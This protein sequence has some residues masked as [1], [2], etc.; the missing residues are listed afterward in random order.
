M[1][2]LSHYDKQLY[3]LRKY[4]NTLKKFLEIHNG[5]L[6]ALT[7]DEVNRIYL[8]LCVKI[9][10][11]LEDDSFKKLRKKTWRI[12]VNLVNPEND[13]EWDMRGKQKCNEFSSA[14]EELFIKN[15]QKTYDL[16]PQDIKVLEQIEKFSE[17]Y[18]SDKMHKALDR[19][20]PVLYPLSKIAEFLSPKDKAQ[21][22]KIS[23]T[24]IC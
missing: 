2:E 13:I 7:R 3:R 14:I 4:Y 16:E 9:E 17:G 1:T 19:A 6:E 24:L 10:E 23:T 8:I 20:M 5:G 22:E 18:E 15:G 12:F 21:K 11:I